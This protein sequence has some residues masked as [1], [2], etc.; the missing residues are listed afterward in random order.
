MSWFVQQRQIWIAE[1]LYIFGYIN[2]EHI[3]RKF[4]VTTVIASKDI[5][6][7]MQDSPTAVVYNKSTKRYELNETASR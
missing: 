5:A 1:T 2:R 4:G 7:F 3:E 6:K